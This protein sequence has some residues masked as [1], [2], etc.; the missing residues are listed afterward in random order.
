MLGRVAD[1]I[2]WLSRY[3]ERASNTARFI[4]ASY[5]LNLDLKINEDEQWSPLVEINEDMEHF[6]KF[7]DSPTRENVIHY[8]IYNPVYPN[9]ITSCLNSACT[10]ARG[11]RESLSIELFQ[12]INEISNIVTPTSRINPTE[13]FS[14]GSTEVILGLITPLIGPIENILPTN[15]A[16]EFPA[17]EKTSMSLSLKALKP[18]EMLL[19]GF[20]LSAFVACSFISMV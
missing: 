8:L 14:L 7:Y 15:M 6:M 3:I 20:F 17:L 12:E 4:E 9:S 10:I 11:L 5:Y 16:P 19:L 13:P 2:Y 18:T 1:N